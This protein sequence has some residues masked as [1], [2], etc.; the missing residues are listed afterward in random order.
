VAVRGEMVR[1]FDGSTVRW[2]GGSRG[3]DNSIR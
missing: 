2:F 1:R 3:P